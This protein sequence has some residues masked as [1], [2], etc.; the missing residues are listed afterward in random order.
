MERILAQEI[1]LGDV[2]V[3]R[4]FDKMGII[5]YTAQIREF[6]YRIATDNLAEGL[7]MIQIING[8]RSFTVQVIIEH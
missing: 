2:S 1:S 3:L 8:E 6:P 4:M 7:Y 5:V